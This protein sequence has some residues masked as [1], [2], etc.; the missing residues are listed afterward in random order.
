[1]PGE[2]GHDEDREGDAV[3]GACEGLPA[4]QHAGAFLAA[5]GVADLCQLAR[6]VVE[7]YEYVAEEKKVAVHTELP[8][9]CEAPVDRIRMR[10]VFANLLDNAIKYTPAGGSVTISVRDESGRAVARFRDTGIGIPVEEQ[11]KIWSRLYRGDK[12]RSQRGLGLG[13]SLVKA[14]VEA[15]GGKATVSSQADQGAEFTVTGVGNSLNALNGS[16]VLQTLQNAAYSWRFKHPTVR[17]ALASVIGDDR[18]LMDI[19]LAGA[20][21]DRLFGEVTC[22]DVGMQGAKVII[23]SDRYDL[24]LARLGKFDLSKS[25]DKRKCHHF[26]AYRCNRDFLVLFVAKYP[27]FISDLKVGSYLYAV[28]DVDVIVKMHE[29]GLLPANKRLEVVSAIRDLAVDTPDAGFL[30]EEIRELHTPAEVEATLEDVRLKLLPNL[31]ATIENW[32]DNY[33]HNKEEPESYFEPLVS[34]LKEFQKELAVHTESAKQ[35]ESALADIKETIWDLVAE[36]PEPDY[37][38]DYRGRSSGSDDDSRSIFDD[39][40]H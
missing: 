40:D 22:G 36:A 32:R 6:E 2:R 27:R 11:D 20:P 24:L 19:Y 25:E 31:A 28:S 15:H 30:R 23:P 35:I 34:A 12:S 5:H 21:V 37:D 9:P 8:A 1:L 17:D 16:L 39:V 29:F 13:L 14:V 4:A 38:D 7:L 26:L 33:Y 3:K 18:E 10:Q